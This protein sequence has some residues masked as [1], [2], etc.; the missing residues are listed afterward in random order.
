MKGKFLKGILAT[1]LA[2]TMFS[3]T[4]YFASAE[5]DNAVEGAEGILDLNSRDVVVKD[6]LTFDEIVAEIANDQNI[7]LNEAAKLLDGNSGN[8]LLRKNGLSTLAA[9]TS[10]TYATLTKQITVKSSYKPELK[11][12]CEVST[13]GS[14]HGIVKIKT[15][16]MNRVYNG[17]SKKYAGKFYVNLEDANRIHYILDGDF[18]NNGTV[19]GEIGGEVGLK[20]SSTLQIKVSGATDHYAGV[21]QEGNVNY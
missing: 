15:F 1:V 12:Y 14:F 9:A 18:Y 20:K 5:E 3:Q 11:F 10:A 6:N 13:S 8:N 21:G 16:Y 19:S 17:M 7:S 2:T 4:N